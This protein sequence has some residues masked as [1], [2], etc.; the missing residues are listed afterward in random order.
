MRVPIDIA[1]IG[2]GIGGVTAALALRQAGFR[3]RLYERDDSTYAHGKGYFLVLDHGLR[4]LHLLGVEDT[5]T[6]ADAM[7]S[8][9][10]VDAT[11]LSPHC[12]LKFPEGFQIPQRYV[13]RKELHDTLLRAC[14]ESGVELHFEHKLESITQHGPRWRLAFKNKSPVECDLLVGA[15]GLNSVVRE[16]VLQDGPPLS[17]G[18]TQ[19]GFAVRKDAGVMETLK[20][21]YPLLSDHRTNFFLSDNGARESIS[22]SV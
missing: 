4:V 1:I 11:T 19:I 15:D 14:E 17:L 5:T 7:G 3:P 18:L 10:M 9:A 13:R 6:I 22:K 20:Q 16:H 8:F 12:V 21:R 2:G